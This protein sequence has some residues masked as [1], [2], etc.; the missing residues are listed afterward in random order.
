M[1]LKGAAA[2]TGYAE[3]PPTKHHDLTP[4]AMTARL[5]RETIADAGFEKGAVDGLITTTPHTGHHG[6]RS[7]HHSHG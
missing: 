6:H 2:I 3:I 1:S 7:G 4:L 5:A